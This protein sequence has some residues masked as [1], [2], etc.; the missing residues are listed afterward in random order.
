MFCPTKH[1]LRPTAT[2]HMNKRTTWLRLRTHSRPL[3]TPKSNTERSFV[4]TVQV[5][6]NCSRGTTLLQTLR[7]EKHGI[8]CR[9]TSSTQRARLNR[10][11]WIPSIQVAISIDYR[12]AMVY[13]Y[14]TSF[15]C[16]MWLLVGPAGACGWGELR[17]F[18]QK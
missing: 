9:T 3:S 4:S 6:S 14:G 12:R 10:Y 8:G 17:V 18:T 2:V 7:N 16:G 13:S 5:G 11:P 1:C 15:L